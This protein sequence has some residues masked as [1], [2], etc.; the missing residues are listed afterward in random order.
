VDLLPFQDVEKLIELGGLL[1]KKLTAS[2][3][4]ITEIK[5]KTQ[6]AIKQLYFK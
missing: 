6:T 3:N 2:S 5:S 4:K 1:S